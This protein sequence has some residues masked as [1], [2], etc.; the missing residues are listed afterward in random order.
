MKNPLT[1]IQT[2]LNNISDETTGE[3]IVGELD[4][5]GT[6]VRRLGR[7]VGDL[8]KLAVLEST[9]VDKSVVD[10][11]DLIN[12]AI[13]AVR[14]SPDSAEREFTL[15]LSNAPWP[16]PKVNGDPDLL[17]LAIHNL[18]DNAIKFSSSGDRLEVRAFEDGK[19]IVVEV[20]DTGQGIPEAETEHVWEELFRGVQARGVPG[21]GLGLSLVK[22]IVEQHGG[23][24]GLRSRPDQG[25][26][27]HMRL[28]IS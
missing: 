6:Q 18:L 4:A 10:I 13:A 2:G 21:S 23:S 16:L 25:T 8:R 22:V 19:E 1:V 24:V 28:P 27:F 11:R 9:P 15:M 5:V 12:E 14:E 3:Y 17:L 20:A 26:V 7:L